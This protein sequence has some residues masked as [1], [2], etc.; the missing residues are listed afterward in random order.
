MKTKNY[1]NDHKGF[2]I[3]KHV[4]EFVFFQWMAI[5][6]LFNKKIQFIFPNEFTLYIYIIVY[7]IEGTSWIKFSFFHLD[8]LSI[9]YELSNLRFCVMFKWNMV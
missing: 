3:Y 6:M 4:F 8:K 5:E 1:W 7:I 9:R 2:S